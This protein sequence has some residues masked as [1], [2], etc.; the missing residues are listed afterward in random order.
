MYW[1]PPATGP[2]IA[3]P[4]ERQHLGQ[5][6]A[7]RGRARRRCGR[8]RRA[9]R[10]ASAA[11]A[12]RSHATQ[13]PARKSSPGARRPR[14]PARRRGGRSSR[15]RTPT[16]A[17]PAAARRPRSPATRLR[18]PSSREASNR[19][20]ASSF[21]RWATSSP[22]RCTTPSRPASAAAGAGSSSGCQASAS[23]PSAARA[24][25]G[26]RDSTVTS[27]PR[28]L[29]R[30]RRAAA[31]PPVAP[32]RHPHDDPSR[33]GRAG[34]TRRGAPLR[35]CRARAGGRASTSLRGAER[36][37]ARGGEVDVGDAAARAPALAAGPASSQPSGAA[38]AVPAT[39][40]T[41]RSGPQ[42]S[43]AATA[44]RFVAAVDHRAQH[45]HRALAGG[46]RLARPVR[47]DAEQ[48]G[49]AQRGGARPLRE[50]EVVADDEPDPAVRRVEHRRRLVA[51][52]EDEL[53]AVPQ[54]RLAVDGADAAARRRSR[55]C[56][57]AGRRRRA[58]RS[59]R[60]SRARAPP[61]ARAQPASV[62]PVAGLGERAR[63]G[64]V[65]EDVARRDE[66]RQHD[67]AARRRRRRRR[68]R[69]APARGSPSSSPT[70]GRAGGRRR[71]SGEPIR[72]RPARATAG[73][74]PPRC[75]LRR[76]P[77]CRP[78]RACPEWS[79]PRR[80]R[81]ARARSCCAR[82]RRHGD[83]F[84][85]RIATEPPWV[86]LAHPDAVREVFTGDPAAAAR[87]QGQRDPAAVPRPRVGAAARR[88]RA[89]A[90]AQ[91]DAAAVPRLAHGGLPRDGRRDR[92]RA[93]RAAGRAASR[94][95]SPR[96]CRR[97]RWTSCCA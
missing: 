1:R 19:R 81:C 32:V 88:A 62:G 10:A 58:R 3:E 85:L 59:R 9:R 27:S 31:D 79:R 78:V 48:L 82:W 90:P 49:A 77:S 30:A 8:A 87:R 34:I 92:A 57:R 63:L 70:R 91:A 5:R 80:S 97:S 29:Q 43:Q 64:G 76:W 84:T 53:L 72:R 26:S 13:I 35:A 41:P 42:R 95:R 93:R 7:R 11:A 54:V 12:S 44:M 6:A 51:G 16:R 4:E 21:Q 15:P 56:C 18:V 40:S 22:A 45:L 39:H 47:R 52:G 14:G 37:V 74:P 73:R 89:P 33:R 75:R 50:L 28:S 23:T 86:M 96:A 94:C 36:L 65:A 46:P 71:A 25:S 17:P 55:R 61:R 66:L 24:R 67:H 38:I 2:P 69:R 20:L 60:R 68:S 83:V